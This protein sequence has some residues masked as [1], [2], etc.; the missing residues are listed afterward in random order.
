MSRIDAKK[1]LLLGLTA[2]CMAAPVAQAEQQDILP[3]SERIQE[4]VN[5]RTETVRIDDYVKT[6]TAGSSEYYPLTFNVRFEYNNAKFVEYTV[7]RGTAVKKGD[8]LARFTITGSE[9]QLTRMELNLKR[10]E[11]AM[12]KEILARKEEIARV[13]SGIAAETN[14]HERQKKELKLR[15][16]E[17]ALEQ[18]VYQQE[19]S[20]ARQKEALSEEI[21]RRETNVLLSPVDGVVTELTYKK[22]DDAV[23][24]SET[25]VTIYSEDVMLLRLDNSNG[26]FRYNMPVTITTGTGDRQVTL[27]GRI[28]AADDAVPESER[29]GHAFVQIDPY[30]A[31]EI[32][33]RNPKVTGDSIRMD[34]VLMVRRTAVTL[35]AGKYYITRLKDGMVQKRY[36]KYGLGNSSDVW[37]MNGAS[38]G[39]QVIVD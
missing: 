16:L 25:L 35:E 24:A 38:E 26:N 1:L 14:V 33:L 5:Y 7:T 29:S 31:E 17:I 21:E 27:T 22:V 30:D 8:V 13:R 9:V 23:S 34:N 10:A 36:I 6:A 39:D 4:Q 19:R 15:K 11:E 2:A 20:I 32:K 12:E 37:I 3:A 18:Y 28:V